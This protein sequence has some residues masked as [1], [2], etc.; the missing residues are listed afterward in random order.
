MTE[1]I[2]LGGRVAKELGLVALVDEM[3]VALVSSF[4]WSVQ[5]TGY[6][7]A[8]IHGQL[9]LMHRLILGLSPG[10]GL[11][12]DHLNLNKLDNRRANLRILPT[13]GANAHNQHSRKGSSS[14]FRG[15]SWDKEKRRWIAYCQVNRHL[16]F[17][18]YFRDENEAAQAAAA[19][20]A[21]HLPYSRE[22]AERV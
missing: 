12:G 1:Q 3:D 11:F 5:N 14:R 22:A 10:D 13:K 15:V 2:V 7:G 4:G 18:G 8:R 6:A 19:F 21:E 16:H 20:R 17:I 9:V